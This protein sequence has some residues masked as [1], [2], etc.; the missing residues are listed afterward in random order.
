MNEQDR[1]AAQ[2][3]PCRALV[4][5]Q[6]GSGPRVAGSAPRP[7]AGFLALLLAH[8]I[9]AEATRG[10]RRAAPVAASLAYARGAALAGD[11]PPACHQLR[12]A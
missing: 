12:T 3:S 11:E 9:G 4:L 5:T 10:R 7:D 1:D 8:R 6:A 2:G